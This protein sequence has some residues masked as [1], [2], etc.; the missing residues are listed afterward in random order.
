MTILHNGA[1]VQ[2][3]RT[4]NNH[5]QYQGLSPAPLPVL[6]HSAATYANAQ[7]GNNYQARRNPTPP[8]LEPPE[9]RKETCPSTRVME[10]VLYD[11]EG[12]TP[13]TAPLERME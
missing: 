12:C 3:F 6:Q 13:E 10:L 8:R 5:R 4:L 1:G 2:R 7:Q 9:L 11:P